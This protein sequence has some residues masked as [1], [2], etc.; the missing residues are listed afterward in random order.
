MFHSGN[1]ATLQERSYSNFAFLATAY[2]EQGNTI[3]SMRGY[4]LEP[5]TDYNRAKREGCDTAIMSGEYEVIPQ[6][7]MKKRIAII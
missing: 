6:N 2:D 3:D 7:E 4:F 1:S 5:G